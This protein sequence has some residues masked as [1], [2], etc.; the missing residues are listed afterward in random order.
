[1]KII[2]VGKNY[3]DHA[4]E[5]DGTVERPS[6]PMIFMK[7]DSAILKNGKPFFVPDF[8]G[9]VEY[10]AEIVVRISNLG[11][12]IPTRFAHRYYD[13]VT[14]GID[15]TARDWQRQLIAEGAPWELSKGFDGA[16]TLGEFVSTEVLDVN[17]LSFRLDIDGKTVQ[18]SNSSNML[19]SI[20]EIVNYVSKYCTLRTGDLIFTGTPAGVGPVAI[21]NHLQGYLQGE[22]VLDFYIR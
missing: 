2:A 5:F 11:K 14:V 18:S 7:P 6:A 16:A 15:F 13:A 9:C 12:N 17:N 21:D 10:E 8:L 20:D 4:L 3:A 1:M 22:K 19:F